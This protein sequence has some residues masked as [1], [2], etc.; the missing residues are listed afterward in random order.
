[1][2]PSVERFNEAK[3]KALMDGLECSEISFMNAMASSYSSRLDS[4][5]FKKD[6]IEFSLI[7]KKW[8]HS[9]NKR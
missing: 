4:V 5:F 8:N 7:S 1:M 6:A 2:S 9:N 3:Y